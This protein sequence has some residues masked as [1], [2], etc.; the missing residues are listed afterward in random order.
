MDIIIFTTEQI[1]NLD[2]NENMG[3]VQNEFAVNVEDPVIANEIA[4]ENLR[5]SLVPSL[6]P[7]EHIVICE[8]E[9]KG[10]FQGPKASQDCAKF[11]IHVLRKPCYV[12]REPFPHE[13][14]QLEC[15]AVNF[16]DI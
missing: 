7:G 16:V 8:G 1:K 9:V 14:E 13:I 3:Q 15:L 11:L 2:S 4:F 10:R 12:H 6:Q 5:S